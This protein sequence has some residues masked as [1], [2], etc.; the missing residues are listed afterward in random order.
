MKIIII[1][2]IHNGIKK[3]NNKSKLG[4]IYA[5]FIINEQNQK[6]KDS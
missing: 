1:F 2:N 4:K 5:F 3:I 6:L